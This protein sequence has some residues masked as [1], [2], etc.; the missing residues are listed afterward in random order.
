MNHWHL[1]HTVASLSAHIL[2]V[3]ELVYA[4]MCAGLKLTDIGPDS[5]RAH[6][7]LGLPTY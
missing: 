3:S 7:R 6:T 4:A 1:H 2:G 5:L